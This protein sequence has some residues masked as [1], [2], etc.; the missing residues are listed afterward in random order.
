MTART[1]SDSLL[2]DSTAPF[3]LL[4][5]EFNILALLYWHTA[6]FG[7]THLTTWFVVPWG[8]SDV[9]TA[10]PYMIIR[11]LIRDT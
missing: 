9:N 5:G 4:Y 10:M 8:T 2:L 7:E 6:L 3:F 11:G 1:S